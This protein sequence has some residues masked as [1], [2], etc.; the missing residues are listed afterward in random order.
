MSIAITIVCKACDNHESACHKINFYLGIP[1]F[2]SSTVMEVAQLSCLAKD[3]GIITVFVSHIV[4]GSIN[5]IPF[6]FHSSVRN[7]GILLVH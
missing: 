2:R 4:A 5:F 6:F 7:S 1:F 3:L